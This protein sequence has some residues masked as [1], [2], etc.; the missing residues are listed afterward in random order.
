MNLPTLGRNLF[1]LDVPLPDVEIAQD[2]CRPGG[3]AVEVS[4][5]VDKVAVPAEGSPYI[6]RGEI[7]GDPSSS[8]DRQAGH[9]DGIK[10]NGNADF[11]LHCTRG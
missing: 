10:T 3:G 9:V 5:E 1:K 7:V 4:R 8:V 11:T 2:P 6:G